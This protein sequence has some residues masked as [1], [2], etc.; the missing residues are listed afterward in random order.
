MK[1]LPKKHCF[2]LKVTDGMRIVMKKC[3]A[4]S[5]YDKVEKFAILVSKVM[6]NEREQKAE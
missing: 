2:I 3:S 5:E 6:T 1:Y 4:D